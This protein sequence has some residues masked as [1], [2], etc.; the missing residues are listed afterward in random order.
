[1]S[2][3]LSF[4]PKSSGVNLFGL[5]VDLFK[6]FRQIKLKYFFS[7]NAAPIGA[8]SIVTADVASTNP[9]IPIGASIKKFKPKSNF[10]PNV[11]NSSI[12]TFCR[13]VEQDALKA[14]EQ[15]FRVSDNLSE[16]ER[17]A[18]TE[19]LD[20]KDLIFKPADKGGG[21]VVQDVHKYRS[22]IAS[23]LTNEKFYRKLKSD[24]T[25]SFQR[26]VF[27]FLDNAKTNGFISKPEFDFL[28]CQH[29]IR[30]VFYTLPKIHKSLVDP[31]GRP[32]VSQMNSLLSPL[33]EFVDFYNKPFVHKLPSYIKDSTDFI[34]NISEIS[35]LPEDTW[36]LTLDVTSLYTNIAHEAGL[37][38]LK[39]YLSQR[40]Q[41]VKPPNQFII[42]LASYV[43]K[44][45]YFSFDNEF[46]L[47]VSGTSMGSIFAPNFANLFM[48]HFEE[49]CVYNTEKNVFKENIIKWYRFIYILTMNCY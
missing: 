1:M 15:P 48:G 7:K 41:T 14:N 19:L 26:E 20:D 40:D 29:P 8:P 44:Y 32:I 46:F 49:N 16:S 36:L 39:F 23:Q 43:L 4:V 24:P 10:R 5:K 9:A 3:G 2:K 21:L 12:N 11:F 31:P 42:D 17:A 37:D 22:E 27:T 47:Q 6:C 45:N 28:Y 34:N 13:L 38:A 35:D 30:P 33:S 25:L 18:L